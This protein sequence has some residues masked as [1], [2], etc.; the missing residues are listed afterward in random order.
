MFPNVYFAPRFFPDRYFPPAGIESAAAL[1]AGLA[2]ALIGA[3]IHTS[4]LISSPV[5]PSGITG[6]ATR[7]GRLNR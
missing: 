4:Q 5:A 6:P 7:T 3:A 2:I 1:T